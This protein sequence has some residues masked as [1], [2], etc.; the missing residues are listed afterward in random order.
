[1]YPCDSV[2]PGDC[3]TGLV[4]PGDKGVPAGLTSTYYKAFAPRVGLAWSPGSSGKTSIRAGWGLFY[5]PIERSW[6]WRSSAPNRLSE[7]VRRSPTF[8]SILRLSDRM[9]PK[10]PILSV[11]LFRRRRD[12][13]STYRYFFRFFSMENSSRISGPST[14]RNTST[15]TIQ[16]ELAKDMMFQLGYVGSQG[17]R[18]LAGHDIN[19]S[20]PQTCL[21]MFNISQYYAPTLADGTAN[22]NANPTLNADYACGPTVED[23]RTMATARPT[24]IP[25][26]YTLHLPYGPRHKS[27][28]EIRGRSDLVGAEAL[29]FP[30]LHPHHRRRLPHRRRPRTH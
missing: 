20:N 16:Q 15:W 28:R 17:H 19:P 7:E 27:D 21:D 6:L 23:S 11:V 8:S 25:A 26:S 24:S 29:L 14:A 3:P 5:N 1:M 30:Q 4:V 18:L 10:T 13:R 12:K 9:A 22:P 2:D